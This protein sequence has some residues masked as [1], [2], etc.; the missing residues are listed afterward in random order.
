MPELRSLLPSA[1]FRIICSGV[2]RRRLVIVLSSSLQSGASDPHG[3]DHYRGITSHG[4]Q[5][6]GLGRGTPPFPPRELVEDGDRREAP[7]EPKP[8]STRPLFG[9]FVATLDEH[10]IIEK[11]TKI[12]STSSLVLKDLQA[13]SLMVDLSPKGQGRVPVL[14][15]A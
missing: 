6:A 7:R 4:Q 14:V 9:G 8:P 11:I 2:C 13:F 5:R 10:I 15:S 1:S 12:A 3:L